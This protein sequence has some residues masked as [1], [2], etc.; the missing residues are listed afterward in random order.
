MN[1]LDARNI[2]CSWNWNP[3]ILTLRADWYCTVVNTAKPFQCTLTQQHLPPSHPEAENSLDKILQTANSACIRAMSKICS[4]LFCSV[5]FTVLTDFTHKINMWSVLSLPM[6]SSNACARQG[7][8]KDSDLPGYLRLN[9]FL[10]TN[11]GWCSQQHSFWFKE[12]VCHLSIAFGLLVCFLPS[13]WKL[14]ISVWSLFCFWL[15]LTFIGL[16]WKCSWCEAN[17]KDIMLGVDAICGFLAIQTPC[18]CIAEQYLLWG[19]TILCSESVHR[20]KSTS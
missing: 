6:T 8:M 9:L 18:R 20:V 10:W 3:T 2:L 13:W 12:H 4:W 1:P 11:D 5:W 7:C 19:K 16:M 14:Q 17:P 15:M